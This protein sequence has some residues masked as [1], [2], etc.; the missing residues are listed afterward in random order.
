MV[1]PSAFPALL[2]TI[3]DSQRLPSGGM[4]DTDPLRPAPDPEAAVA[5]AHVMMRLLGEDEGVARV[6]RFTLLERVAQGGMGV[7]FA[8]YDP[9]LDRKIAVKLLRSDTTEAS[10]RKRIVREAQAMAKLSHPNVAQVFEVGEHQGSTFIAMEFVRG[11]TLRDWQKTARAWREILEV[12]VQAGRGLA[13]AHAA[14]LVHRDFKP[15]NAI[16]G[17]EGR[18]RVLDFGLARTGELATTTELETQ[19]VLP[20][21]HDDMLG[22]PL[23]HAGSIMGTPAYMA[24]EQFLGEEVTARSDQFAYC[25]ALWEGLYG[26]RPFTGSTRA[27][28]IANVTRGRV[29]EAPKGTRVPAWVRVVLVR[30]LSVGPSERFATTDELLAALESDPSR[31]RRRIALVGGSIVAV[32]LGVAGVDGMRRYERAQ[33]IAAC[34][35]ASASIGEVWNDAAKARLHDALVGTG[36]SYAKSSFEHAVPFVDKHVASWRETYASQ[37]VATQVEGTWSSELWA[38]SQECLEERRGELAALLEVLTEQADATVVERTVTAAAGLSRLEPC[39]DEAWLARHP[40]AREAVEVATIRRRM[41]QVGGLSTAGKSD[42]ALTLAQ[43][44]VAEAETLGDARLHGSALLL[45]GEV[46]ELTGA[47]D[48]SERLLGEAFDLALASGHHDDARAAATAMVSTVG[49]RKARPDE[50]LWWGRVARGL[51]TSLGLDG[52]LASTRLDNSLANVYVARGSY[53][54]AQRLYERGVAIRERALG[55][56]HPG[57]A[58]ILNNLA[59]LHFSRGSYDEAQ[60]LH[61]R[62]LAIDEGA[63]GPD[64]PNIA[65]SLTGLANVHHARGSYDEAQRLH[66]RALAIWERALGPDHPDVAVSLNNLANVHSARDSYDEAQRLYERAIAIYEGALGPDHPHVAL[67]LANLANAHFFRGS[68]DEAQRLYER[69]LAI[70]ERALGPDHP[71]IA[72]TL[73]GL[74]EVALATGRLDQARVQAERAVDVRTRAG[75]GAEEVAESQLVLAKVLWATGDRPRAR[76]LARA[77]RDE[78][79]DAGVPRQPHLAEAEEL[80]AADRSADE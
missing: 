49:Y 55:P 53:D 11:E 4:P 8:A 69:A 66:E 5:R 56:D 23:T 35:G 22:T 31:R 63:L 54:E 2:E 10:M 78:F 7:V 52:G 30:G 72:N 62:T 1:G 59:T 74:A 67:P 6:G 77:A 61:E 28:L 20:S 80:L 75:V 27:D 73:V 68:D 32:A 57:V 25:V 13:A 37:C 39:T 29:R 26:E 40:R 19:T 71:D 18:V 76:E 34:E 24:P 44:V 36:V 9:E 16:V 50:G 60:R 70:R 58:G 64:H 3:E 48:E 51:V 12:Y 43:E 45:A 65:N 41:W 42:E 79:R 46:A 21:P 15:D 47:Y 14:G 38:A 17:R 33:K